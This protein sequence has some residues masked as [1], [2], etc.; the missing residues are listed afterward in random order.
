MDQH[1]SLSDDLP[2]DVILRLALRVRRAWPESLHLTASAIGFRGREGDFVRVAMAMQD[3][4]W[5]MYDALL[6]GTSPEPEFQ[7][8][9][10]TAK[11]RERMLEFAARNVHSK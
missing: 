11:G 1:L 7:N 9:C 2:P 10:M 8:V 3:A 6:I 5:I 4:G